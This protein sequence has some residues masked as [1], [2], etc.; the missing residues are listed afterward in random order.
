M[1]QDVSDRALQTA[2]A[3][4]LPGVVQPNPGRLSQPLSR[5]S[6]GLQTRRHPMLKHYLEL[7]FGKK[8][9]QKHGV[10]LCHFIKAKEGSS[11]CFISCYRNSHHLFTQQLLPWKRGIRVSSFHIPLWV[12]R[13][14]YV[15]PYHV[16]IQ[17]LVH[18]P[19]CP[20]AGRYFCHFTSNIFN[21][22]R[23]TFHECVYFGSGSFFVQKG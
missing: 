4:L 7:H 21:S 15:T 9:N 18:H 12:G 13:L 3:L 2:C 19:L 10:E 20:R 6:S 5:H 8:R 17:H 23:P 11:D 14:P 16:K 1:H 22:T